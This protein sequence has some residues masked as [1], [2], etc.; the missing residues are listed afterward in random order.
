[1]AMPSI[2]ALLTESQGQRSSAYST[3]WARFGVQAGYVCFIYE[4][5]TPD[6][7]T[8]S[9]SCSSA[10]SCVGRSLKNF[11]VALECSV[12]HFVGVCVYVFVF[13]FFETSSLISRNT[14]FCGGDSRSH[15][16][17]SPS[18]H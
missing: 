12:L 6:L 10:R 1:M 9:A 7:L 8:C 13:A 17:V 5:A 2:L 4:L 14:M 15:M 16:S 3:C 18:V 11:N